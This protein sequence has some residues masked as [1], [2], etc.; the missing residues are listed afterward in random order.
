MSITIHKLPPLLET[1]FVEEASSI[2]TSAWGN[3]LE[4][5]GFLGPDI[6]HLAGE[7]IMA[8]WALTV[9]CPGDN[10]LATYLALQ[11]MLDIAA[12]GRWVMVVTGQE[13][14]EPAKSALWGYLQSLM[15]WEVGFVGAVVDGFCRDVDEIRMKMAKEFS[16]FA[17]SGCPIHPVQDVHGEIGR[18]VSINGV[19]IRTGDLILG[20]SDGVICVPRDQVEMASTL[21][22]QTII[23][24]VNVVQHVR[25][26]MGAVDVL[27]LREML[28]GNVDIV[29]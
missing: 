21:C 14:A 6:S 24:E 22:R 7:G 23:D 27:G 11:Y 13:G 4:G 17:R 29:E 12:T 5:S 10:N 28:T 1:Y 20:D 9:A 19:T 26:G 3:A 25:E 2:P 15:G 18:P 16:I 8:G